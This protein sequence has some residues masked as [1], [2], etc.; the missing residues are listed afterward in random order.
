MHAKSFDVFLSHCREDQLAVES[1]AC[2]LEDIAQLK[3]WLDIWHLVPG[4]PW[5]EGLEL[6]LDASRT[7]AVFIGPH[8]IGPWEHEEMRVG[9]EFLVCYENQRLASLAE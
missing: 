1:I 6:A 2:Q 4:E 9:G 3:P 8:G 7:C 5:Q